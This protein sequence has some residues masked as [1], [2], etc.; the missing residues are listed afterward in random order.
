MVKFEGSANGVTV[1]KTLK[2]KELISFLSLVD[3]TNIASFLQKFI[4]RVTEAVYETSFGKLRAEA[5]MVLGHVLFFLNDFKGQKLVVSEVTL[6]LSITARGCR[7]YFEAQTEDNPFIRG[8]FWPHSRRVET[9][10]EE[11]ETKTKS[12]P[13]KIVLTVMEQE[14]LKEKVLALI[15]AKGLIMDEVPSIVRLSRP[16]V[17]KILLRPISRLSS[18]SY[19]QSIHSR[20]LEYNF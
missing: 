13:E 5:Y 8:I 7:V 17:N 12:K 3:D 9:I 1:T 6:S 14:R 15:E 10:D 19:L 11:I 20:L 18:G 16:T 2:G 4:D